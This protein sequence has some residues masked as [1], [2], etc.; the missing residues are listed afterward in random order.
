M[1]KTT[2]TTPVAIN[3]LSVSAIGQ[4]LHTMLVKYLA[5]IWVLSDEEVAFPLG[6]EQQ[7][8]LMESLDVNDLAKLSGY[9]EAIINL[10]DDNMHGADTNDELGT[11]WMDA[12]KLQTIASWTI[13]KK[14]GIQVQEDMKNFRSDMGLAA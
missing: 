2:V 4:M 1:K 3:S 10:M 9:M 12:A 7:D 6:K 13:A 11:F 8:R 14:T 5:D